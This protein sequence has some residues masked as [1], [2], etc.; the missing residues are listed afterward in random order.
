MSCGAGGSVLLT[1]T[2]TTTGSH[3]L[4]C[5]QALVVARQFIRWLLT[6]NTR[7]SMYIDRHTHTLCLYL[8][9][10][11]L[12][13]FSHS[14]THKHKISQIWQSQTT[15]TQKKRQNLAKGSMAVNSSSPVSVFHQRYERPI[16]FC[17]QSGNTFSPK[18]QSWGSFKH[19]SLMAPPSMLLSSLTSSLDATHVSSQALVLEIRIVSEYQDTCRA[20]A[21]FA[22][23]YILRLCVSQAR[24]HC[25]C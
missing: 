7:R 15:E 2:T 1:N 25:W 16:R 21:L 4:R 17:C 23:Y 5:A 12:L 20:R 10:P 19:W 14:Y 11:L 18:T 24:W 22:L 6:Q 8:S 9:R 3:W 13:S